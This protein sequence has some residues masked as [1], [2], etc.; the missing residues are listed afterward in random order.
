MSF[1][2]GENQLSYI[3]CMFVFPHYQ[4]SAMWVLVEYEIDYTK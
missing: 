4:Y 2:K 3:L 1:L